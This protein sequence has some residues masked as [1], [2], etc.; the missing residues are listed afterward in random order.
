MPSLRH[1]LAANA[2]INNK[3]FESEISKLQCDEAL[4]S[5]QGRAVEKFKDNREPMNVTNMSFVE[6]MLFN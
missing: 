2:D 4:S 6:R 5:Q 1:Y 3:L